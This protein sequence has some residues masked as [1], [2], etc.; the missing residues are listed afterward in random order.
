MIGLG[1]NR[2][3]VCRRGG[4]RVTQAGKGGMEWLAGYREPSWASPYSAQATAYL[5]Q[6]YTAYWNDIL[7]YG[8]SNPTMVPYI[9]EDPDLV[10]SLMNVGKV[11][12]VQGDGTAYIDTGLKF[13]ENGEYE[14]KYRVR[15]TGHYPM[16]LGT[17][18]QDG[19]GFAVDKS[20]GTTSQITIRNYVST[21]YSVGEND[22]LL[23]LSWTQYTIN[24]TT[25]ST[26]KE[27]ITSTNTVYL[28]GVRSYDKWT[29]RIYY[30][31]YREGD[32]EVRHF[33]PFIHDNNGTK[34]N[35]FLD[36]VTGTFS[37]PASGSFTISETPAS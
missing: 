30:A 29:G 23:K 18:W 17:N 27:P 21:A 3:S 26:G 15:N 25:V 6:Y 7:R 37:K 28:G 4:M 5:Q 32:T 11:R 34:E 14:I 19:N 33:V 16:L 12:W 13:A 9:N 22:V 8:L 24:G 20:S 10:C 36:L 2:L 31:I 1:S 35:G